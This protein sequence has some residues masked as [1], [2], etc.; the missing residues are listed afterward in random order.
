MLS[1]D[2]LAMLNTNYEIVPESYLE[3]YEKSW[4]DDGW[5]NE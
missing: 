4:N 1:K 2:E 3:E 5:D